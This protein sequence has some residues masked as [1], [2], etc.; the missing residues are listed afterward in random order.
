MITVGG[1][2]AKRSTRVS[3]P[4]MPTSSSLTI[5]MTCCAGLSA[6]LTSAP[7]ARSLTAPM[8]AL[9]TGSATSASSSAIR[10]SRAVASMSASDSRPLPRRD[11]KTLSSRSESVSNIRPQ[12]LGDGAAEPSARVARRQPPP[13]AARTC[14]AHPLAQRGVG[15]AVR[16]P[17]RRGRRRRRRR[18]RASRCARCGRRARSAASAA[19]TR[20]SRPRRSGARTSSTVA[21]ARGVVDAARRRAARPAGRGAGR[22]PPRG[23]RATALERE[24][25]VERPAQVVAHD[26]PVGQR[27]EARRDPA[28]RHGRRALRRHRR[29]AHVEP[30]Q[31]QHA[32]DGRQQA[33]T[34]GRDDRDLVALRPTG[35]TRR[36][37]P[38]PPARRRAGPAAAA[39]A[40]ASRASVR[41]TRASTSPAF[42]D[43]PGRRSGRRRV[44]LGQGVQ[45]LEHLRR[46]DG[47]GDGA[48]RRRVGE[49]AAGRGVGQQ[50]VVLDE[51]H[52]H[53]DVRGRQAR[54]AGASSATTRMPTTGVVAGQALADVVQQRTEQQQV[55]TRAPA[56]SAPAAAAAAS[57]RCRST[58]KRW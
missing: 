15:A 13:S 39:A 43:R 26:G 18:R 52:Q 47:V 19:V 21:V 58:V 48:R 17:G 51:G 36:R 22:T 23:P 37:R 27:A 4:R 2:L 14:A 1:V 35:R 32:G 24:L 55:R 44:G 9:T 25:A 56:G 30:V 28:D 10:I 54:G 33:R 53:V 5:L 6:W 16:R 40:P 12:H 50:Q 38:A 49:V 29:R 42:H 20:C 45:Q 7:R 8:K 57:T 46:A 11:V 34:V 31:R 3:P 41:R